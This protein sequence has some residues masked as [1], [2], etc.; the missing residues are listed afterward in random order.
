[1][2]DVC[3][4]CNFRCV[5]CPTSDKELLRSV[6]RPIGLMQLSLYKSIIDQLTA[7]GGNIAVLSLHKDGEPLLH[8][9]I[10]EMVAYATS[11]KV[12][13]ST[14]I[15]TN[16]S[17]LSPALS[18]ALLDAGLNAIRIS[19]EHVTNEGYLR[20]TQNYDD[21]DSILENVRYFYSEARRRRSA[22]KILAKIIDT[23][24]SNS[25]R[26]KFIRDF[27]P[28]SDVAR[29]EGIM[30]WS[31]SNIKDFTLGLN[32]RVGMDG[33]TPIKPSRIVC[34]EPFKMLAINFN[35][36]VSPCCDDWA[37]AL[38]IGDITKKSIPEIWNGPELGRLR[39]AHLQGLRSEY[40]ACAH[41]H[42]MLGVTDLFDLDDAR[43]RLLKRYNYD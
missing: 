11:H 19:V 5:F 42:Y 22:T 20:V 8:K 24:L 31:N 35:G 16:A 39:K 13:S 43:E 29:I 10:A 30:G 4:A 1:M 21:Y 14:E 41:C 33:V 40:A 7:F 2:I 9:D 28:I 38:I 36:T 32:P 23:G 15:T 25:E 3:N 26:E 17:R 18:D 12:A 27:R 37:L 6:N 34:P